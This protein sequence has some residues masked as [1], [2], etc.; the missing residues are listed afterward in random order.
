MLICKKALLGIIVALGFF[1]A[2]EATAHLML[3]APPPTSALIRIQVASLVMDGATAR[4]AHAIDPRQDMTVVVDKGD[5]KR[6]IVIGGSSVRHTYTASPE[7]NF[8]THLARALPDMDVVN[9]GSPGQSTVGLSKLVRELAPLEPDLV[10]LYT[11]HNDFSAALFQGSVQ[12]P[13]FWLL[14]VYGVLG[15]SW[16]YASLERRTRPLLQPTPGQPDHRVIATADDLALRSRDDVLENYETGL[17]TIIRGSPAPVVLS[18]LA[19]NFDTPPTGAL[20]KGHPNCASFIEVF[21]DKS[22]RPDPSRATSRS[23]QA[24]GEDAALTAWLFAQAARNDG[25]TAEAAHHWQR[26]LDADPLPL[27]APATADAVIRAV[28]ADEGAVLVDVEAALGPILGGALFL[29][30]LHPSP[31]G[32]ARLAEVMAPTIREALA[33]APPQ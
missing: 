28:A 26:S 5:K 33:T 3:G 20:T 22:Y 2:G 18:T 32:A 14:P 30:T 10:V 24:C 1:L 23:A 7:G 27:R 25:R 19:R 21:N 13:I 6:I 4:L 11:G 17:R 9:F 12:A 16:L 29:D 31:E 8:P 15:K